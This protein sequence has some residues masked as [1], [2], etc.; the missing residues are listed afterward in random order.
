MGF[1]PTIGCPRCRFS[2]QHDFGS[3]RRLDR[4]LRPQ[5][6][7]PR[8]HQSKPRIGWPRR[9]VVTQGARLASGITRSARSRQP[10][11]L[12]PRNQTR[13]RRAPTPAVLHEMSRTALD[14]D[15]VTH[16]APAS[17]PVGLAREPPQSPGCFT[18]LPRAGAGNPCRRV[19]RASGADAGRCA[20]GH[21]LG[22][23][24]DCAARR[25][26]AGARRLVHVLLRPIAGHQAGRTRDR[27]IDGRPLLREPYDGGVERTRCLASRNGP[28]PV[29]PPGWHMRHPRSRH[30]AY[31]RRRLGAE[32]VTEGAARSANM[33]PR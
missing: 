3:T 1:E 13:G 15:R 33:R 7:P 11:I 24:D 31:G 28:R 14:G 19:G 8:A 5:L 9:A 23:T 20:R 29:H 22:N 32:G 30:P 17:K 2:R 6:R 27:R 10:S 16:S 25:D 4:C 12:R 26:E 21:D 18:V